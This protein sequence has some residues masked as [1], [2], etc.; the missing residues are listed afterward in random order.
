[1]KDLIKPIP[2]RFKGGAADEHRI[3]SLQLGQ[4]LI[5]I[6]KIYNSIGHLH[7]HG[8][9]QYSEHSQI[10]M[11]AS[12]PKTGSIFY[13]LYMMLL[14][15]K[16]AVY[17]ELYF[18]AAE[19]IIPTFFKAII[20]KKSGQD[21]LVERCLNLI[22]KQQHDYARLAESS[23][24]IAKQTNGRLF[25]VL[26]QMVSRNGTAL[27][28]VAS[29]VGRSI[30]EI[31]QVPNS[32]EPILID[33]PVAEALRAPEELRVGELEKYIGKITM[34]DKETGSFKFTESKTGSRI[35]GK[36]TD[37]VVRTPEN[38]YTHAVDTDTLI[39]MT[40]KPTYKESGDLHK[41][42]VSDGKNAEQ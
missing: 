42:F 34:I 25:N 27:S 30:D 4:S 26:D 9:F 40:A 15:G 16:L 19:V 14:H 24:E 29:S 13:L 31:E 7:F 37:P 35:S 38:I 2:L 6:S 21:Q 11:H 23:Q 8:E 22:E 39:E 20:G 3:D 5:G 41:I 18:E 12:P 10:R 1:L 36:I 28:E 33:A 32:V 17:P